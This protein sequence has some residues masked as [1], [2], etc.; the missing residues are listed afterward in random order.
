MGWPDMRSRWLLM[1]ATRTSLVAGLMVVMGC[2]EDSGP[3]GPR[4]DCGFEEDTAFLF[5]AIELDEMRST[6]SCPEVTPS[7][8]NGADEPDCDRRLEGCE[9][10]LSCAID[11]IEGL[12]LRARGRLESGA[13][14][15]T[16]EGS[17]SV[18]FSGVECVYDVVVAPE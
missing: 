10:V 16:L 7:L 4:D 6:G 13:E 5:T 9:L 1:A 18:E 14:D 3:P 17:V 2:G 12:D 8:V 15:D 11:V